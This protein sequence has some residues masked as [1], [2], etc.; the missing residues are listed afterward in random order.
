MKNTR[1]L[2]NVFLVV[3]LFSVFPVFNVLAEDDL[4]LSN[5]DANFILNRLPAVITDQWIDSIVQA[6]SGKEQAAIVILKQASQ[7]RTFNYLLE[8]APKEVVKEVARV[9]W[10]IY[11]IGSGSELHEIIGSFEKETANEAVNYLLKVIKEQKL[12]ISFGDFEAEYQTIDEALLKTKFQYIIIYKPVTE[13]QGLVTIRIY[14]PNNL[15]PPKSK[16]DPWSGAINYTWFSDSEIEN[17]KIVPPF[18]AQ[19]NG[20]MERKKS[21]YWQKDVI[22]EYSFSGSPNLTITFPETVPKLEFPKEGW[23]GKILSAAKD[24]LQTIAELLGAN[25]VKEEELKPQNESSTST[26]SFEEELAQKIAELEKKYNEANADS[27]TTISELNKLKK[28]MT[29]LLKQFANLAG[30]KEKEQPE[31]QDAEAGDSKEAVIEKPEADT[32]EFKLVISEICS[33]MDNSKSEFVEIFNPNDFAVN[34]NDENFSLWIVD[35][36]DKPTQKRITW[37]RNNIPAKGY[38]LFAGSELFFSGL[39]FDA[40]AYYSNQITSTGGVIISQK[41]GEDFDKAGWGKLS[42]PAP[43]TSIEGE[44]KV[45]EN[46]LESGISIVR[47]MFGQGYIDTDNNERD[48]ETSHFPSPKNSLNQES[49]YYPKSQYNF[50]SSPTFSNPSSNSQIVSPKILISEIKNKGENSSDDFIELFNPNDQDANLQGWQLK[51]KTSSGTES[52]IILFGENQIIKSKQYLVWASTKDGYNQII[53]A[54]ASSSAYLA[55]NNSVALL[56]KEKQIIDAVAWQESINPFVEGNYFDSSHEKDQSIGRKKDGQSY[57]DSNNNATDFEIQTST[58]KL[59][60]QKYPIVIPPENQEPDEEPGNTETQCLA[61]GI[62]IS[63][64]KLG[65]TEYVEI[66]N[67][68]LQAV[69]LS[70]CF[71]SYFSA[72]NDWNDP[73]RNWEFA[74]NLSI[75]SRQH[76]LIGIYADPIN[77]LNFDWQVQSSSGNNYASQ[78]LSQN[79]AI[80]V[81]SCD[82][83]SQ[84]DS[85]SA[86]NCKVDAVGWDSSLVKEENNTEPSPEE[87]SMARIIDPDEIGQLAYK[88]TNDNNQDFEIQDPTPRT[89]SD[90]DFTDLDNDGLLDVK[91]INVTIGFSTFLDPGEYIFKN[92]TI[93]DNST[94]TLKGNCNDDLGVK[95]IV[96]NLTIESGSSISANSQGCP[97]GSGDGAGYFGSGGGYGGRGA[98]DNSIEGQDSYYGDGGL[99][100]GDIILPSNLGSGGG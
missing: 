38:F 34:I 95:L 82:P 75:S 40:D 48:F 59:I 12:K 39:K 64:V 99:T 11:N 91:D 98:G 90:H 1:R 60:N 79:G 32:K 84:L 44:G 49:V 58:P 86:K 25:L 29:T 41:S 2:K 56:D 94:I 89:F 83:S 9:G 37:T 16:G 8:Q 51:K 27:K 31:G 97:S 17:S 24:K 73:S 10:Q 20:S 69:N 43:E 13:T 93:T 71:L 28:D 87:K 21:G 81:F 57:T 3:F 33:G 15:T 88:D 14:S 55:D 92:L 66:F 30:S 52:S 77:T 78:Q 96:K 18:I 53:Q 26:M 61:S 6:K 62:I 4:L 80:G 23:L 74:D 50:P 72:L 76:F 54:D 67:P 19:I 46:G 68:T 42:S 85:S 70:K 35:S 47:K 63:E 22:H 5:Y 100:Y 65:K 45:L 7:Q 36:K